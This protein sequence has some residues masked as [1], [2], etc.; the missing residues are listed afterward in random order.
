M[1]SMEFPLLR[2]AL[3]PRNTL[4]LTM[5]R[6]SPIGRGILTGDIQKPED[7]S[8]SDMRSHMPRFQGENFEK[9]LVLV[10]KLQ[11]LAK[12]KGCA[13]AQ[14][15]LSVSLPACCNMDPL[16]HKLTYCSGYD[17]CPRRTAILRSYRYQAPPRS[18]VS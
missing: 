1:L 14:L 5:H 12:Q 3:L 15:A 9:N 11:D 8:Q 7:I 17:T 6:Y 18:N 2:K 16:L 13:P 10:R 4:Q